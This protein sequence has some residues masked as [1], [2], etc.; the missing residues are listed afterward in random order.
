MRLVSG[1]L[2]SLFL[3]ASHPAYLA[4]QNG[5]ARSVTALAA[6]SDGSVLIV[7]LVDASTTG[8]SIAAF[9][10]S[11]GRTAWQHPSIHLPTALVLSHDNRTLAVG[12]AGVPENDA[13]VLLYSTATGV[14]M[15][16]L[17]IDA[18]LGFAPGEQYASWGN[19]VVG[20]A[21]SP[22]KTTLYGVSNDD[23]FAWDLQ[24]KH[25][26]WTTEVPADPAHAKD[27]PDLIAFGHTTGLALSPDGKQLVAGRGVLQVTSASSLRPA[28]FIRR[29]ADRSALE[30]AAAP[31]FSADSRILSG[32]YSADTK[33]TVALKYWMGSNFKP[34]QVDGCG[35]GMAWTDNPDVFGCQNASGAHLRNIHAA[36]KDIGAPGP[37]SDLP[38]LK[39]GNSLWSVAYKVSDWKDATKSLPLTLVEL[40]TGKQLTIML[41]GRGK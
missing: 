11:S 4:G 6:A 24:E 27:G 35:G 12:F 36:T 9:V 20:L 25:Y 3:V 18:S 38:I 41:P 26:L 37:V 30:L 31:A 34:T 23:L 33:G 8:G 22:D 21:F 16:S 15:G 2:C 39:V 40:G 19:G 28:H 17:G 5:V 1:V 29:G 7:A 32:S 10:P 13:G 14:E